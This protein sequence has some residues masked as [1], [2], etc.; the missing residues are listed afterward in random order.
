MLEEEYDDPDEPIGYID[1]DG[2]KEAAYP[3]KPNP[4]AE[5]KYKRKWCWEC[6]KSFS[7]S[8]NL[9]EHQV[10]DSLYILNP[11]MLIR[12]VTMFSLQMTV[13]MK[14]AD[15]FCPYEGCGYKTARISCYQ[16]HIKRIHLKWKGD[17]EILILDNLSIVLNNEQSH[18]SRLQ[19]ST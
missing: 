5:R 13:H 17:F 12:F 15:K 4:N 11:S 3:L 7:S 2:G 1:D 14:E 16:A 8:T 18:L 6:S 19:V 9:K 10:S